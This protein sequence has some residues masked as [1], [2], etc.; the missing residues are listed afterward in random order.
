VLE[1]IRICHRGY[2][3]RIAFADFLA[4]YHIL[5]PSTNGQ[6]NGPGVCPRLGVE[7][8]CQGLGLSMERYQIGRTKVRSD[9]REVPKMEGNELINIKIAN[10]K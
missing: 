1:G 9:K 4:R 7:R 2:P 6:E 10:W 3:N 5:W 8:L